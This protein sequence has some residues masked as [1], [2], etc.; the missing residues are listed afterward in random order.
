MTKSIRITEKTHSKL[1]VHVAKHKVNIVGF[2]D[3]A[4]RKGM[5]DHEWVKEFSE[6]REKLN[7]IL[8]PKN[9]KQ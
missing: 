3:W 7:N 9:K 5:E 1:K 8:K 4:V 2:A 6:Y